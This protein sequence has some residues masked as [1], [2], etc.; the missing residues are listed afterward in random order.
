MRRFIGA[1]IVVVWI[2]VLGMHVRR[3]YFKGEE[4]LLTEGARALAPGSYFYTIRMEGRAIGLSTS[5]LDT[6][7]EGFV[8]EDMT[9]LDVPALGEMNRAMAR[10]HV[11][12]GPSLT[13]LSF[14]FDLDSE[15][16]RF[17]VTGETHGD[18]VLELQV[19]AGANAQTSRI[20]LTEPLVIPAALPFRL[21]ASGRLEAGREF[22]AELFDPSVL[23]TRELVIRVIE[24]D[25]L[26]VPDSAALDENGVWQPAGYDTV[27][28]WR[29]EEAVGDIGTT[30]W[31]DED[32]RMIRSESLLGFSI[33]RTEYELASQAWN[34][35]R[36]DTTSAEASGYG[37][38]IESTAIASDV[39]L[40]D[41]AYIGDLRV[42]L[43]GVD[44]AG[45][46]LAGGRQTL[47]GDTLRI[48]VERPGAMAPRWRL[49]YDIQDERA[50][51]EVGWFLPPDPRVR[52]GPLPKTGLV[53]QS[54]DV[55]V[56]ARG[57][58]YVSDKNHGVY[59][60]RHTPAQ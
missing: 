18:S 37:T 50:P 8:F 1:A 59:I 41:A 13:V 27:P 34:I 31:I 44:L 53:A 60:L 57:N 4:V 2:G 28:V 36:A 54:E 42:R 6:V 11:V 23:A 45:F 26:I 7:P 24:R 47:R 3:E 32:G 19:G 51:K 22:R 40:D 17:R 9:R 55:V 43:R 25:T 56:D 35:E 49:P 30:S 58:I 33:E 21:A 14:E 39:P 46:D 15:V 16:G 12:L 5:R 10:S 20:A 52:R 48:V 29:I 38:L